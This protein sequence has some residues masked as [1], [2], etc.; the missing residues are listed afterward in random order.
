MIHASVDV[1]AVF[2]AA[3]ALAGEGLTAGGA[4]AALG[5]ARA[6]QDDGTVAAEEVARLLERA[7]RGDDAIS[8]ACEDA[9]RAG[10]PGGYRCDRAGIALLN[11]LGVDPAITAAIAMVTSELETDPIYFELTDSDGRRTGVQV[12]GT[13]SGMTLEIDLLPDM[14]MVWTSDG[15]TMRKS[16]PDT[17][18]VAAE[19]R[20]LASIISH[21]ALDGFGLVIERVR[22]NKDGRM[23]IKT[24]GAGTVDVLGRDPADNGERA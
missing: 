5:L 10:S 7:L 19:G 17:L 6:V 23:R 20:P 16:I 9:V 24:T 2:T 12:A 4:A 18:I 21:P 14:E 15:V 3:I 11:H 8:R 1:E 13:P 22:L